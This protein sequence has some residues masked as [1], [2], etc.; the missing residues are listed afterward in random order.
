MGQKMAD[1]NIHDGAVWCGADGARTK[2]KSSTAPVTYGRLFA[3]DSEGQYV[4]TCGSLCGII[5]RVS[6][7]EFLISTNARAKIETN[8]LQS[9]IK[10]KK[11]NRHCY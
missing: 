10:K 2:S 1:L 6:I 4:L 3:F 7:R 5:Y 9:R 11:L 8:G